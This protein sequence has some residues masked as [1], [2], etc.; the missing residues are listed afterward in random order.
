MSTVKNVR[1]TFKMLEESVKYVE[2][3]SIEW[4]GPDGPLG[5][6]ETLQ[7]IIDEHRTKPDL[8]P[9]LVE[10]C[11]RLSDELKRMAAIAEKEGVIIRENWG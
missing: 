7:R 9:G 11:V 8:N 10:R 3:K 1:K 4:G 6:E 2:K 5:Q